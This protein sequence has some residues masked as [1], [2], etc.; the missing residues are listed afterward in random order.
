MP[1][2][3]SGE[4]VIKGNE[5]FLISNDIVL[6]DSFL[7]VVNLKQISKHGSFFYVYDIGNFEKKYSFGDIGAGPNDFS[8]PLSIKA[9][10]S[11]GS[12]SVVDLN[13][14]R[15]VKI[16]LSKSS[17]AAINSEKIDSHLSLSFNLNQT[18]DNVFFG[19]KNEKPS[20]G[21]FFKYSKLQE[22]IEW[23]DY[24]AANEK[25]IGA[26]NR[27]DLYYNAL[28]I[29][30]NAKVVIVAFRYFNKILFFDYEGK[31]LNDV[32]IGETEIFPSWDSE[33]ASISRI[34][35]TYFY[36]V[37]SS[38]NYIYCLWVENLGDVIN[39]MI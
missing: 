18:Q 32:Q 28:C 24:A 8:F 4:V 30:E 35:A 38:D 25:K 3:V 7:V 20:K 11:S 19:V 37:A 22:K 17:V 15:I 2:K 27:H 36:D 39:C 21:I 12:F 34:S 16:A 31:L 9:K 33:N 6:L 5:D 10:N 14:Q 26:G 23:I 1:Y 29:N 13:L